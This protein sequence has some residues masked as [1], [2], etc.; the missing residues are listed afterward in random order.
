MNS[1]NVLICRDALARWREKIPRNNSRIEPLNRIQL[2][3][4]TANCRRFSF[5]RGEKAGMRASEII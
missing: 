1:G 5:S 4:S 3:E 2:F